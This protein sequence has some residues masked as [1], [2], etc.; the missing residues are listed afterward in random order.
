MPLE[1]KSISL[2]TAV[3]SVFIVAVIGWFMELE[4][5]VCCKR[6]VIGAVAAYILT[7]IAVNIIN[8]ILIS[9]LVNFRM[10]QQEGQLNGRGS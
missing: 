5:F 2:R 8:H 1:G 6:A 7:R 4:P 10:K 9:A 3:A